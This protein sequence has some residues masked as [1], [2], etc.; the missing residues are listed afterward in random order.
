MKINKLAFIALV[1][2][3]SA[4]SK[5]SN[6]IIEN[7][8]A[9]YTLGIDKNNGDVRVFKELANDKDFLLYNGH[10]LINT[11]DVKIIKKYSNVKHED[12]IE[13]EEL[14]RLHKHN[15][16]KI[17][18]NK[19]T[20]NPKTDP[21][22]IFAG[23]NTWQ[24]NMVFLALNISDMS[25]GLEDAILNGIAVW[26]KANP[27]LEFHVITVKDGQKVPDGATVI[28][29]YAGQYHGKLCAATIGARPNNQ[30]LVYFTDNCGITDIVHQLG[31]V[32]GYVDEN[33]RPKSSQYINIHQNA[34]DSLIQFATQ[35]VANNLKFSLQAQRVIKDDP[36]FDRY[37]IMMT[38]S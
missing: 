18:V 34:I 4:C 33:V 8:S 28:K 35:K 1:I 11:N 14:S 17:D 9:D 38:P 16:F 20:R 2:F 3:T 15:E 7:E 26:K 23:A 12:S 22:C 21:V 6:N 24:C 32:L 31:H 25:Y 27:N 29:Y 5:S 30:G 36:K 19:Q 13:I 10:N 37:S